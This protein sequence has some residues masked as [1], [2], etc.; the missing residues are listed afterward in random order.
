MIAGLKKE[1]MEVR[2]ELKREE[3]AGVR[4]S[5]EIE[6]LKRKNNERPVTPTRE[7]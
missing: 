3:E 4:Q 2:F 6:K 5:V 1:V 7:V